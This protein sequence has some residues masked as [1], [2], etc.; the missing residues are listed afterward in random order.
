MTL[1]HPDPRY[2]LQELR[3]PFFTAS[4]VPVILGGAL[5]HGQAGHLD[6]PLFLLTLA[7][8]IL[9]HAGANTAN[10]YYD[11]LSGNDAA[12]T[13]YIRP[14][15]GGS[16]LIQNGLLAPA[17]VLALSLG[18]FAIGGLI[19]LY[20][21][22]QAGWGVALLAAAG[23]AGGFFYTAPPFKFGYRG[24]G[25]LIVALNFG[26]LPLAG[27]YY[28]QTR[29]LPPVIL[30]AAVPIALLVTAI[31]F[32][33]QFPDYEA[34]RAVAKRNWVVRLGPIGARPV[35]AALM[36]LWPLPIV[37]GVACRGL[38]WTALFATA[39]ILPAWWAIR[40]VWRHADDPARMVRANALTI[41]I[42][43]GVGLALAVG[44]ALR[45]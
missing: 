17:H 44:V 19:G 37:A 45:P 29:S 13:R 3:A 12:N 27:T 20:L 21:A 10:D 34:D 5:V 16:R 15:T 23:I 38:P 4:A 36:V 30:F 33:N 8:V 28:V 39:G 2:L 24:W 40:I 6:W 11:H 42:H 31:L 25:E 35:Y 22:W 43:L 26:V 18:C 7:G 41:A 1:A 9:I 14:F 32:I